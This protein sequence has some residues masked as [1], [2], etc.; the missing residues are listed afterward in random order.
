MN[1]AATLNKYL[2]KE[3]A[4]RFGEGAR[5]DLP[6]EAQWEY[7][8]RAGSKTTYAFGDS[9]DGSQ[10]N[11]NGMSP[12]PNRTAPGDYVGGTTAVGMYPPNAWG[13]Y[14][15]HGNVW[16]WTLDWY[17]S[18][19]VKNTVDPVNLA[20]RGSNRVLRGGA[21]AYDAWS[22][23]AANRVNDS[24]VVFGT[25]GASVGFRLIIVPGDE[26]PLVEK[27]GDAH[28]EEIAKRQREE[29]EKSREKQIK[30]VR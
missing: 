17:A 28:A 22:A 2:G 27:Y 15:M 19:D 6:T 30:G 29:F 1:F 9:C 8:C 23:R 26:K 12:Y 11:V 4:K 5:Y 13:L 18:Y 20:G 7:A 3:L 21:W 14:D 25:E 10:A 16:E 24:D